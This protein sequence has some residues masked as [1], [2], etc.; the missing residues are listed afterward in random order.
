MSELEKR[1]MQAQ[2]GGFGDLEQIQRGA[3]GANASQASESLAQLLQQYQAT[4][5]MPSQADLASAQQFAQASTAPQQ[6][7]IDLAMRQAQ[8]SAAQQAGLMGR[9]GNDFAL[10]TRLGQQRTDAM[11]A[12]GAQQSAIGAQYAQQLA[13]NRLGF[14]GQLADLRQGL[15]TQAMQN[16]M[17]IMGLGSQIQGR[18]QQF[19]TANATTTSSSPN[20]GGGL[21]GAITGALG[22]ASAAM[23][24]SSLFGGG[25]AA[26]AGG[27]ASDSA[28]P[29][30]TMDFGAIAN[31]VSAPRVSASRAPASA[32]VAAF[33]PQ[34]SMSPMQSSGPD[35]FGAG[36]WSLGNSIN[37]AN[38]NTVN[39]T[40]PFWQRY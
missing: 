26:A 19:R 17:A 29:L 38:I 37:Q 9:R 28:A 1:A 21:M 7:Q 22:G 23:N 35:V 32:P 3:L 34:Q 27:I 4:G 18:E 16:R 12:L 40:V 6:Q 15:A 8:Q 10:N 39:Q 20:R 33:T 31:S 30:A 11:S 24:M 2:L 13:Q 36:A 5:G 14:A 25:E